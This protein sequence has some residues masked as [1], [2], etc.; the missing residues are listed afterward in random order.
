MEENTIQ[1]WTTS[2]F[3]QIY[4]E[5]P[6]ILPTRLRLPDGLTRYT[7]SCSLEDIVLCGYLGPYSVPTVANDEIAYWDSSIN[8][9]S[10]RKK[11]PEEL[12]SDLVDESVRQSISQTIAS[13]I[14]Y[15]DPKYNFTQEY[16]DLLTAYYSKL[17]D[18]L[19]TKTKLTYSDI[20]AEPNCIVKTNEELTVWCAKYW[21][22]QKGIFKDQYETWAVIFECEKRYIP[23]FSVPSDWVLG[24]TPVPS[25]YTGPITLDFRNT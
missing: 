24:T 25:D 7:Y 3:N 6:Y 11:T 15:N 21:E 20:P 16:K 14:D 5:E 22:N 19:N 12:K 13:K 18:I 2:L 10:I 23:F 4:G 1:D 8:K 9:F 17:S